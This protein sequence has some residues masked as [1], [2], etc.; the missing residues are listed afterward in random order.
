M[1]NHRLCVCRRIWLEGPAFTVS[2]VRCW[3]LCLFPAP[4]P[5]TGPVHSSPILSSSSSLLPDLYVFL[6]PPSPLSLPPRPYFSYTQ[7]AHKHPLYLPWL[8]SWFS[9][10]HSGCA[11]D[12]RNNSPSLTQPTL[13]ALHII[14]QLIVPRLRGSYNLKSLLQRRKHEIQRD[15]MTCSWSQD[16]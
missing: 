6:P 8:L 7:L 14:N 13:C 9:L 5:P 16:D 2:S 3:I 4:S 12:V 1:P 15:A 10:T 11:L